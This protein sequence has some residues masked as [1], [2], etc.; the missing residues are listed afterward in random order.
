M[1]IVLHA[2]WNNSRQ[3]LLAIGTIPDFGV[4]QQRTMI[5]KVLSHQLLNLSQVVLSNMEFGRM[6]DAKRS[7]LRM[8]AMISVETDR[9]EEVERYGVDWARADDA[10]A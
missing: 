5:P 7:L 4:F 1:G 9:S 8:A 2:Y 6:P 3:R 10:T